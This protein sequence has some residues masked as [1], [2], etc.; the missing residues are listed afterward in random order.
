M[1]NFTLPTPRLLLNKVTI[2]QKLHEFRDAAPSVEV[3][4]ALKANADE[5]LVRFF[6]SMG[7]GFEIST[8]GELQLLQRLGVAPD[9]IISGNT[10]RSPEFIRS[11]HL[12]GIAQ[13]CVDSF[14]EVEKL[15]R[16]A[17]GSRILVRLAVDNSGSEWPL[18]EKFGAPRDEA[19]ELLFQTRAAGLQPCGVTFHV[20]SQSVDVASWGKALEETHWVWEKASLGGLDLRVLN[21]GGGFPAHYVRAVPSIAEIFRYLLPCVENKFGTDIQLQ[22]EPGRGLVAEAGTLL[23][24]VLG[25]SKRSGAYWLHLDVGVFNGLIESLGGIKYIFSLYGEAQRGEQREWVIAGPSCDSMDVI[26]RGVVLPEPEDGDILLIHTA[27]AYTSAY[28]SSFNG[29][30]IPRVELVEGTEAWLAPL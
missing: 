29:C 6:V 19:L 30:D 25:K 7:A 17:P 28:A 4:Y 14:G 9:R 10:I 8:M 15:A 18:A 12:Y 11:S 23:T 27:G 22:A 26:A 5:Q 1:T 16:E 21:L 3:F 2:Q 20:G 13:F 24:R